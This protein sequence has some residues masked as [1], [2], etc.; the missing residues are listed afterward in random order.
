MGVYIEPQVWVV[1]LRGEKQV[2]RVPLPGLVFTG[3]GYDYSLWAVQGRPTSAAAR[4]YVAPCPNLTN[5]G[6]CR[7]NAP[8]PEAHPNTIWS[9]VEVFFTS[10]F[11]QDLGDGKSKRYPQNVLNMWRHLSQ[12]GAEEYPLTDLVETNFTL[13]RLINVD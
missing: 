8:F 9:A 12:N 1:S 5:Q 2:L 6:V 11:N 4:L 10:R 13:E 7:G 3:R